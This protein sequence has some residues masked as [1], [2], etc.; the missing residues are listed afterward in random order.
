MLA[1]AL[2]GPVSDAPDGIRP[3]L[4]NKDA[5]HKRVRILAVLNASDV[6]DPED[7][8]K[9]RG[10][11]LHQDVERICRGLSPGVS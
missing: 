2:P 1:C 4:E 6:N 8:K 3:I 11:L 10:V 7:L 9:G 5:Q